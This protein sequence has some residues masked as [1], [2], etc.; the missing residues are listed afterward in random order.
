MDSKYEKFF[1]DALDK[2]KIN[3][4]ADLKTDEEKKKF[5]NY[6]DS[7]YKAKNEQISKFSD[8]YINKDIANKF[9]KVVRLVVESEIKKMKKK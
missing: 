6:V 2:F 5:Y 1:N 9:R 4:P 8:T 3:S 7:N